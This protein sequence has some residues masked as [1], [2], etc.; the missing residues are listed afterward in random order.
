MA[1]KYLPVLSLVPMNMVTFM[2]KGLCR[3]DRS[4]GPWY[5][6]INLCYPG[7][8]NLITWCLT[9]ENFSWQPKIREV[10][11]WEGF[12]LPLLSLTMEDVTLAASRDWKRGQKD[13][14]LGLPDRTF[15]LK[16]MSL[17]GF[18]NCHSV[19]APCIKRKQNIPPFPLLIFDTNLLANCFFHIFSYISGLISLLFWARDPE[20]LCHGSG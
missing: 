14:L 6:E 7:G 10:S 16:S 3:C 4:E 1:P 2:A 12:E 18:L 19:S 8:P 5:A 13:S 15:L 17:Q 11:K 9:V 20:L